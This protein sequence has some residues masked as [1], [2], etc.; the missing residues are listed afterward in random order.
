M[1]TPPRRRQERKKG[2]SLAASFRRYCYLSHAGRAAFAL[3]IVGLPPPASCRDGT[4]KRVWAREGPRAAK[5]WRQLPNS[6]G[7]RDPSR[8][9]IALSLFFRPLPPLW[10]AVESTFYCCGGRRRRRG[11]GEPQL[12]LTPVAEAGAGIHHFGQYL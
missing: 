3:A 2:A 9:N 12:L 11:G 4:I 10:G 8:L 5:L 7:G 6:H 1:V